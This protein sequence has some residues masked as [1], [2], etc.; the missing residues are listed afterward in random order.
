MRKRSDKTC[1]GTFCRIFYTKTSERLQLVPTLTARTCRCR[2]ICCLFLFFLLLWL[3]LL[4]HQLFSQLI[5]LLLQADDPLLHLLD[6]LG[7]DQPV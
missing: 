6:R 2:S 5:H 7:L 1:A 3:P 4:L